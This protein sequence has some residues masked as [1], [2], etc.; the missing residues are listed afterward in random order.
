MVGTRS[1]A[2]PFLG[3][4]GTRWNASLP[5]EAT[6]LITGL[7]ALPETRQATKTLA[8]GPVQPVCSTLSW[9]PSVAPLAARAS[10][11]M[12]IIR[13]NR[14][15]VHKRRAQPFDGADRRAVIRV[16]RD[17]HHL[18]NRADE[19]SDRPASLKRITISP[20][21]L[22]DSKSDVPGAKP[23]VL[24]IP[25]AKVDVAHI[26]TAFS[27]NAK[28]VIGHQASRWLARHKPNKSEPHTAE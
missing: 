3:R 18:V 12:R 4:S 6:M 15:L 1:T 26:R 14:D 21:G 25:H 11:V 7:V 2:S 8:R 27:Q 10:L 22:C 19:G 13:R 28:M 24:R 9:P 16:A 23:H 20:E 17:R 5:K